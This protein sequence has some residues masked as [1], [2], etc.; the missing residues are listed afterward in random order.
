MKAFRR[1]KLRRLWGLRGAVGRGT[2][3]DDPDRSSVMCARRLARPL[4]S[5][6][7]KRRQGLFHRH[8]AV[9]GLDTFAAERVPRGACLLRRVIAVGVGDRLAHEQRGIAAELELVVGV[10]QAGLPEVVGAVLAEILDDG[11]GGR[12]VRLRPAVSPERRI[13][14]RVE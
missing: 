1:S 2:V 6:G 7:P 5:W 4:P 14:P 12:Q 3:W 10:D 13:Y 11:R 8:C 9:G